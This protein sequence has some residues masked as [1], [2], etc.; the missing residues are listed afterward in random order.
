MDRD[1]NSS[2]SNY[3][4]DELILCFPQEKIS[5]FEDKIETPSDIYRFDNRTKLSPENYK[6]IENFF[7]KRL[8]IEN[9]EHPLV[10]KYDEKIE[11]LKLQEKI[12]A[13]E[14]K[15][16]NDDSVD[17]N[18]FLEEKEHVVIVF[19]KKNGKNT[20]STRK[21]D[22]QYKNFLRQEI[23][24]TLANKFN[25]KRLSVRESKR[26]YELESRV[27]EFLINIGSQLK[28]DSSKK[29]ECLKK[30]IY[31]KDS[32]IL[33][34]GLP[35]NTTFQFNIDNSCHSVKKE[36]FSINQDI[37]PLLLK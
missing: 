13:L 15:F 7:V 4:E 14:K 28:Y 25:I 22:E 29:N 1:K 12:A 21:K 24:P 27:N 16:S 20:Y 2:I 37:D 5:I 8:R 11:R 6:A 36:K 30:Q 33:L 10:I 23:Y 31:L 17:S 18:T 3:S 35:Y 34:I 9:P 26:K 19:G 32:T